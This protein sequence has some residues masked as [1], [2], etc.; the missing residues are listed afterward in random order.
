M[1]EQSIIEQAHYLLYEAESKHAFSKLNI[2]AGSDISYD[3]STNST[4]RTQMLCR[5]Q[6]FM[7]STVNPYSNESG[8]H[9]N[10]HKIV[11]DRAWTYWSCDSSI[12]HC[13]FM[14]A[15][16]I[17]MFDAYSDWFQR[18][19]ARGNDIPSF[20]YSFLGTVSEHC[21]SLTRHPSLPCWYTPT[22]YLR[23][24]VAP[25]VP[26]PCNHLTSIVVDDL[27]NSFNDDC[28]CVCSLQT[29]Y[30]SSPGYSRAPKPSSTSGSTRTLR[31]RCARRP[32]IMPRTTIRRVP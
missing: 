24:F 2:T 13:P 32:V 9:A 18:D 15:H 19:P 21:R 28:V 6:Q 14:C 30:C 11:E 16:R 12:A 26:V 27:A 22:A 1:A 31:P 7:K 20:F 4:P 29:T 23:N 5:L 10:V 17:P 3:D 25:G 8:M